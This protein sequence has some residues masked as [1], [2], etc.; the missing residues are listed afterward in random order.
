MQDFGDLLEM[1]KKSKADM[2]NDLLDE[3][4]MSEEIM[5]Q[6]GAYMEER[7]DQ[8]G[9]DNF[10]DL[11]DKFSGDEKLTD[12]H[13]LIQKA[14]EERDARHQLDPTAFDVVKQLQEE[15]HLQE[16]QE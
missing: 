7:L 14:E 9:V 5:A 16:E 4:F 11:F 10:D 12:L 15:P 1:E 6:D 8:H 2:I 13:D 3:M